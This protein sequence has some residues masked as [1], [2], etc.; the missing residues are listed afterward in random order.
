MTTDELISRQSMLKMQ[1]MNMEFKNL[2]VKA[3]LK[4]TSSKDYMLYK[5]YKQMLANSSS[6]EEK[7][8]LLA[9]LNRLESY[10]AVSD[11]LYMMN[12][13]DSVKN[14]LRL[15]TE[16]Y[17]LDKKI[18]EMNESKVAIEVPMT[19]KLVKKSK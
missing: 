14:Y 1:I 7:T 16:Y 19:K 13:C 4:F 8:V 15:K 10:G 9:K 18:N 3:F 12:S 17:L 6:A 2:F 5:E 11:Y